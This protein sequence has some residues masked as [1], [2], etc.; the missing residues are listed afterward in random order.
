MHKRKHA[1]LSWS[2]GKDSAMA[3]YEAKL[4]GELNI[5]TLFSTIELPS[6][7]IRMHRIHSSLIELQTMRIGLP[8]KQVFISDRADSVEYRNQFLAEMEPFKKIGIKHIV[9]GDIFLE[10]VRAYKVAL[11][12]EIEMETI[13]PLWKKDSAQLANRFFLAG[14]KAKVICVN[15]KY[16]AGDFVGREYD[17]DFIS[18]LP[19]GV[20]PCGERGEF[21]TFV[22]DGPIFRKGIHVKPGERYFLNYEGLSPNIDTAFWYCPLDLYYAS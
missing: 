5:T 11:S 1:L 10:E 6:S 15:A 20:D 16:L 13:F 14:F 19:E 3:L 4:S 18:D 22:Y 9:Y 12:S 21:H 7:R 17:E 2:G 8:L